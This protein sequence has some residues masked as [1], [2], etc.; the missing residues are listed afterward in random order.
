MADKN[1]PF[2]IPHSTAAQ[3]TLGAQKTLQ[4]KISFSASPQR[5]KRAPLA[6]LPHNEEEAFEITSEPPL[7][8]F[9]CQHYN[10]CLSLAAILEWE[11]FTC[12]G[13]NGCMNKQ[14][15]WRGHQRLKREKDLRAIYRLPELS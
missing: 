1:G 11:S 13:C 8:N 5:H 2:P 12:D 4:G 6:L 15:L 10:A 14:L 7:R 9:D 3:K